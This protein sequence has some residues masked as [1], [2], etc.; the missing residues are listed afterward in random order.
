MSFDHRFIAS[1]AVR[2]RNG[3]RDFT[4]Y[5]SVDNAVELCLKPDVTQEGHPEL[6]WN[7]SCR[8]LTLSGV[9]TEQE[10]SPEANA[11]CGASGA[12]FTS[13]AN[14]QSV[15]PVASPS[16]ASHRSGSRS[17]RC[18]TAVTSI[19]PSRTTIAVSWM[20]PG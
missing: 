2:K 1:A 5:H 13:L 18:S 10:R 15:M 20:S 7:T 9:Q 3:K 16:M 11:T 8:W 12:Y 14:A 6:W 17:M 19:P 4:Y